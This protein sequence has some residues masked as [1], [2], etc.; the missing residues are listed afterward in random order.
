MDAEEF[1]SYWRVIRKRLWLILLLLVATLGVILAMTLTAPPVYRATVKM[2]VVG[3]EPQQVSLFS[4]VYSGSVTDEIGAV[5]SEFS[6]ALKNGVVAWRTIASLNL[7]IGAIDLLDRVSVS[8]DGDA[9]YVTAQADTPQ[10]AE[11]I[12]NEHVDQA[13]TYYR[14][15]RALPAQVTLQFLSQAVTDAEVQLAGAQDALLKFKLENNLDSLAR[16]L[17]AYQDLIRSLTAQRDQS[18]VEE[19]RTRQTAAS[20]QV[21]AESARVEWEKW[22]GNE[23]ATATQAYYQETM[24]RYEQLAADQEALVAG[25]RAARDEYDQLIQQKENE[26]LALIGLSE[27]LS[28]LERSIGLARSNYDFLLSKENEAKLKEL[29]ALE[30]GYIQIVEPARTPDAPAQSDLPR[31]A[32]VG[33]VASLLAGIILAFILEFFEQLGRAAAGKGRERA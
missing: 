12:V 29:T 2:Q 4:T 10:E 5:Q 8:R 15:Y 25:H 9:L 26:L 11:A 32:A 14:E 7:S 17:S 19:L 21:R 28:R 23:E 33:G 24:R 1:L 20:Y 13:L 3:S 27:E 16:E 6:S 31:L 30:I 22:S 18:R